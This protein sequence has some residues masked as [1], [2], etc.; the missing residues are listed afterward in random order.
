MGSV[1]FLDRAKG[2]NQVNHDLKVSVIIPNYNYGRYLGE[3]I[4]S[5]LDQTLKPHEVIVVDDGS[6]DDSVEVAR[7]FGSEVKVIVQE[8]A[9]VGAARNRGV[10][11]S[12]GDIVAFLDS[13]DR[14]YPEK[15]EHQM[16]IFSEDQEVGIVTCFMREFDSEGNTVAVY[17]QEI[18]G[19]IADRVLRLDASVVGPGSAVVL[20][21]H[22]FEAVGGFDVER[23][24]HPSEDWEF[25]YRVTRITKIRYVPELL[26][27]YRN[28]GGNGHLN[29]RRM[30]RAM[31]LGY[32]KIFSKD[33]SV[34]SRIRR[35]CYANLHAMLA[36]SFFRSGDY[37]KFMEH[38]CKGL[39]RNPLTIPRYLGYP[40]RVFRRKLVDHD[41]A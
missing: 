4:Q 35:S 14:W 28:H 1:I 7:S 3:A 16:K 20:R 18:D 39:L 2:G 26:V 8:N 38:S 12:T 36:G 24:L 21:K 25:F 9:G 19:H 15:L 29:I 33:T 13:D 31:L 5:V 32:S 10:Q 30:E 40:I 27:H 6:K 22:L 23:E 17:T 11:E 37:R 41:G 34:D